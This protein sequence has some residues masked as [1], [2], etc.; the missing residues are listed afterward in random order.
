MITT[1]SKQDDYLTEFTDG[2]HVGQCDAPVGKGG[3]DA[4][5]TPFALL[6]ASLAGCL[7]ITLRA[8]AKSHD[9][10]LGHVETTVTLVPGESG[11]TF[12]YSV[13]LP[14]GVSE[15]DTKRLLAALKGC[16][17]HGLLGKPVTFELKA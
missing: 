12:E 13:E 3:R 9:I 16:P 5:F 8:F 2:D 7:N 15:K 17:I 4:A 11:T 14:E 1:K 6:E 10:E